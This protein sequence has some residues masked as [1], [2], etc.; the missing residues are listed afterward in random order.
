[1]QSGT[2][3]KFWEVTLEGATVVTCF[4]RI[5]TAGQES[6]KTLADAAKAQA[7]LERLVKEKTAKGYVELIA[8]APETVYLEHSGLQEFFEVSEANN[9]LRVRRGRVTQ[10]CLEYDAPFV[11][12]GRGREQ[13]ERLVAE[14]TERG[15]RRLEAHA[16]IIAGSVAHSLFCD[17]IEDHPVYAQ[18]FDLGW[19]SESRGTNGRLFHFRDGLR[20]HHDFDLEEVADIGLSA[21][22]II[23]G[24]VVVDGVFSQLSYTYPSSTLI[25][26]HVRAHSF[27]HRDSFLR[28]LGDVRVDN[29]V[30]GEYNDGSLEIQ[31]TAFGTAWISADHS[32]WASRFEIE[33]VGEDYDVLSPK[34]ISLSGSL[35]WDAVREFMYAN[36][37]PF[38][39]GYTPAPRL[40][41]E[42]PST[43]S[44][45]SLLLLEVRA[46]VEDEDTE[47]LTRLLEAWTNRDDGWRAFVEQRLLAPSTTPEQRVRLQAL[48][49]GEW[50]APPAE[51]GIVET[52]RAHPAVKK[53]L[54]TIMHRGVDRTLEALETLEPALVPVHSYVL[55]NAVREAT[56]SDNTRFLE[57]M[58]RLLELG[59]DPSLGFADRNVIKEILER[60]DAH[61]FD[62]LDLIYK[63]HPHLEPDDSAWTP[64]E[65]GQVTDLP[66]AHPRVTRIV[67]LMTNPVDPED[68]MNW[69][70]VRDALEQPFADGVIVAHS[71]LLLQTALQRMYA[72]TSRYLEV[73]E[74]L[75]DLG[76][77]PR[78]T[79]QGAEVGTVKYAEYLDLNAALAL[80]YERFPALRPVPTP[81]EEVVHGDDILGFLNRAQDEGADFTQPGMAMTVDQI[82]RLQLV[83]KR[84]K[85]IP[86]TLG[87]LHRL[88]SLSFV[89]LE[90][91][92]RALPDSLGDLVNLEELVLGMSGFKRV[93]D[94]S[95]LTKLRELSVR[96]NKLTA[97]PTLPPT[98]ERLIY[99]ENPI[100]ERVDVSSLT[101]LKFLSLDGVKSMP[102]GLEA[103]HDLEV[104]SAA[105]C[106]LEAFPTALLGLSK[107]E[108][109]LLSSNPLG[110]VPDLSALQHLTTLDVRNA[111]LE[112]LP[113]G[114]LNLPKLEVLLLE[115]NR[116]LEKRLQSGQDEVYAV[117][118]ARGVRFAL[119]DETQ[120]E[121]V[122]RKP[123]AAT[124]ADLKE[125][126]RLN[127][128]ASD[129]QVA[130]PLE[131]RTLY[132]RVLERTTPHLETFPEEF[133]NNHLFALQGCLWCVN[134]LAQT[135]PSLTQ[136]AV[137]YAEAILEF[138]GGNGTTFYYS[139]ESELIRAAQTLAHN[140][141]AWYTLQTGAN[142]DA[143]LEH[144]N[145][146]AEDL[147]YSSE[148]GSFAVVYEN[149]VKILQAL[150]RDDDAHAIVYRMR[151]E[152]PDLE[153]FARSADTDAYRAWDEAN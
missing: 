150:G 149:K 125:V 52:H 100:Q 74:R 144:I 123:D 139:A 106:K 67:R 58:K 44:S 109:L 63:F 140:A 2:S 48:L 112:R 151:R 86:A 99:D 60:D 62:M 133:T 66:Q 137:F 77:D 50:Q 5:G 37:S 115:G 82:Y 98:L 97:L 34:L 75:L 61:A 27:G 41:T 122:K 119:E 31:G 81:P 135:D 35:D 14:W 131:A 18:F 146:A 46:R 73:I 93:P 79:A 84:V 71:S 43:E 49:S 87:Q 153:P 92:G 152:Y 55:L 90:P 40:E 4:G 141:L 53:L 9:H 22:L 116:A 6:R 24:D 65:G 38:R 128:Q 102:D 57:V 68:A 148:E 126:K 95:K 69:T 114:L 51:M 33:V 19:A 26:G 117:L 124:R 147:G 47:G 15:F 136:T 94:L 45:E 3:A 54:E 78:L 12:P 130:Q 101:K 32:M 1:M 17:E 29:I 20:V 89:M 132:E 16:P 105:G 113:D 134:E 11:T 13:F 138:T 91:A 103:L 111:K 85:R 10:P 64:P 110:S 96:G 142:L 25:T 120:S 143:A 107:L 118:E 80:F 129:I 76:A 83:F 145:A 108:K 8:H 28:V 30:Y 56:E 23:E 59:A 88:R 36:K 70:Y 121:P 21:G 104:F 42:V 72:D 39:K 127:Q 7:D